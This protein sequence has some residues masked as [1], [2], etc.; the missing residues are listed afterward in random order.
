MRSQSVSGVQNSHNSR[1]APT[2]AIRKGSSTANSMFGCSWETRA[3]LKARA[4]SAPVLAADAG[5]CEGKVMGAAG[6]NACR[7]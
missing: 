3:R 6:R 4:T 1:M 5:G 2:R 7:V